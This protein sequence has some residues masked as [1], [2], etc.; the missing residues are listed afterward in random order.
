MGNFKTNIK[1]KRKAGSNHEYF[2]IT[3][4]GGQFNFQN[5]NTGGSGQKVNA[6]AITKTNFYAGGFQNTLGAQQNGIGNVDPTAMK[7]PQ[8]MIA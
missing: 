1:E 2:N 8:H 3:N 5:Q 4:G 7:S 6:K